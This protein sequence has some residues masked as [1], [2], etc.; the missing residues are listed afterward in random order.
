MR[1]IVAIF[2]LAFIAAIQ[3]TLAGPTGVK[4]P[5]E[6]NRASLEAQFE[7][8]QL[9]KRT[10]LGDPATS[11]SIFAVL[12]TRSEARQLAQ[13]KKATVTIRGVPLTDTDRLNGWTERVQ[14]TLRCKHIRF[15][16]NQWSEW[17]PGCSAD[18]VP[19]AI[20]TWSADLVKRDGKWERRPS[21]MRHAF[22]PDTVEARRLLLAAKPPVSAT[23]SSANA[24]SPA[25]TVH[26]G[27]NFRSRYG[28]YL[29][30]IQRRIDAQ[31]RMHL[32]ARNASPGT[33]RIQVGVRVNRFGECSI[34][35]ISGSNSGELMDAATEAIAAASRE[36]LTGFGGW[37]SEM[38][39]ALGTHTD[40][41]VVLRF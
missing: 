38:V 2:A 30:K 23:P 39:A 36:S 34:L 3:Q 8:V 37:S 1:R 32:S 28:E 25:V 12:G 24:T 4:V 16:R 20:G 33:G 15:W 27:R 41:V 26:A 31:W 18:F 11:D 7:A 17:S 10:F 22:A 13:L 19:A 21:L 5:A 40:I 9:I 6:A 35:E 14:V 29:M